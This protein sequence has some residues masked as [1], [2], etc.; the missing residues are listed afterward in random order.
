MTKPVTGSL[1]CVA[2]VILI[3]CVAAVASGQTV[4]EAE[5]LPIP[6]HVEMQPW[7]VRR[8]T[9]DSLARTPIEE[10]EILGDFYIPKEGLDPGLIAVVQFQ[11]L[12]WYDALRFAS[13]S[14]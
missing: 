9:Y 14:G 12:G 4:T 10:L 1:P 13:E 11:V 8:A 7:Q 2:G 5:K 3:G 6:A